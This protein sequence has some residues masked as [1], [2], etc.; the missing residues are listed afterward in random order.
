MIWILIAI[1]AAYLIYHFLS[2]DIRKASKVIA[3]S[4]NVKPTM[5]V[6]CIGSMRTDPSPALG[7]SS[8]QQ[9]YCSS[10]IRA[11]GN[12][13]ELGSLVKV[14]YICQILK[15]PHDENVLWWAN[16]LKDCGFDSQITALDRQTFE[17]FFEVEHSALK[18]FT[19]EHNKI[20]I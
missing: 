9:Y 7:K 16:R 4:L 2:G 5:V 15:N 20:L 13:E 19:N 12:L 14:F 11:H 10:V 18:D 6:E 8:R 3:Y 1:I 17:M